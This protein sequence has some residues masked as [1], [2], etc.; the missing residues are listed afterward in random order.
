ME[1]SEQYL[2]YEE[3]RLLGGTLDI[4]PFNLLEFETRKQIDKRTQYRLKNVSEIPKEVKIC[5][6]NIIVSIKK[7]AEDIENAKDN[8]SSEN[9]DGYSVTYLTSDKIQ[10]IIK[11][12]DTEIEDIISTQLFGVIINKVPITYLGVI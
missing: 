7:Y 12:K 4:M 8:I 9:T 11:S 6:Y 2:T 1:F 3:Y 5:M 10:E